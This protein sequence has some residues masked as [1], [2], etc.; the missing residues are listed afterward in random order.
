MR[1][2][3]ICL[4]KN[5][6]KAFPKDKPVLDIEEFVADYILA[7]G[8]IAPP[9]RVGDTLYVISQMKDKRIL[10]F[11]NEYEATYIQV[12][13]RKCKVYHEKDGF[14]KIFL[15]D[16]FGKTVFLTREE[17]EAALKGKGE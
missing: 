9:C 10:P 1:D 13:K 11:V 2:R 4:I 8:I 7:D 5:A 12:G 16:D 14:I 15:Q 6:E 17:A 3:L